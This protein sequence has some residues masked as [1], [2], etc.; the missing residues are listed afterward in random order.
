MKKP[1]LISL[2]LLVT[3]CT[4]TSCKQEAP[5]IPTINLE[6]YSGDIDMKL[7]DL[8]SDIRIVK[9]ESNEHSIVSGYEFAI[10]ED[11]IVATD[12]NSIKLFNRDGKYIRNLVYHGRGPNEYLDLYSIYIDNNNILYCSDGKKIL[13]IDIDNNKFLDPITTTLTPLVVAA[14]S[15]NS[16]YMVKG[17]TIM[18][19]DPLGNDSTFLF[20]NYNIEKGTETDIR[21]HYPLKPLF[22]YDNL[23]PY[24]D[25]LVYINRNYSDSI[26]KLRSDRLE[27]ILRV[28]LENDAA[29]NESGYT[30]FISFV[31]KPGIIFD[32]REQNVE[33]TPIEGGYSSKTTTR[34]IDYLLYNDKSGLQRINSIFI[35]PLGI[36]F[37]TEEFLEQV[38]KREMPQIYPLFS[39][40]TGD[41]GY[42]SY[43]AY[44][45]INLLEYA[46]SENKNNPEADNLRAILENLKEDDNPVLIIGKIK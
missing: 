13:R 2:L 43:D 18:R 39:V 35:N 33:I 38:N 32:Y 12:E 20:A 27:P 30:T 45:M 26:F 5:D 29:S 16:L 17:N 44:R 14:I 23:H 37:T 36:R 10:S 42:Y 46:L 19:G 9:L 7:S 21:S 11:Y 22:P 28:K 4:V 3:I 34:I 41:Y 6:K 15:R 25:E 24:K 1:A 8:L 40:K 31:G